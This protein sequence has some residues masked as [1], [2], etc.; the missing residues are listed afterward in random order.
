[1]DNQDK[2]RQL[3]ELRATISDKQEK[4]LMD[5]A[6]HGEIIKKGLQFLTEVELGNAPPMEMIKK[7]V[8]IDDKKL[9]QYRNNLGVPQIV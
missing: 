9:D 3:N 4:I 8:T 1:M 7:N 2:I 5:K 6:I